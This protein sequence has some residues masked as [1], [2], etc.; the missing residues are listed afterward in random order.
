MPQAPVLVVGASGQL[1]TRVVRGLARQGIPV[2]AFVRPASRQD[3][4]RGP[5]VELVHGDLTD[6]ASIDSAC[7]GAR[8]VVATANAVAP[9]GGGG[10]EAVEGR[11]YADLMAACKRQGVSRF[12]M[13]SVSV[14]AGEMQVPTFRYKRLNEARLRDS[15][16]D[17]TVLRAAPFMDDWFCFMGS[18]LPARGDDAALIARP[19]PFLQRFIGAIENMIER[20]GLALVPGPA[21]TRHAFIAIDDVAQFLV[22]AIDDAQARNAVFEIGGP[23]VLSWREVA[24]IFARV[25]GRPVRALST[26]AFVFRAQQRLMQ[27]FSEAAANVMG[28]NWIAAQ[29]TLYDAKA[30]AARLRIQLTPAEDF[31][32]AKA[33]LPP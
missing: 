3:H 27:P 17:H 29:E 2:R 10:F 18:R 13:I 22:S 23:Q 19:W 6:P 31:L 8:A 1:G 33:A 5:G 14:A 20:R 32:R 9:V 7:R 11:G 25:L 15:G 16:L 4:L 12:V 24:E 30:L 26:P 21:T 28:L